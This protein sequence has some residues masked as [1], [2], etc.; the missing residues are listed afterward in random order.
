MPGYLEP[1]ELVHPTTPELEAGLDA[2][3]HSPADRGRV[4]QI[5]RRPAV[6]ER[7]ALTEAQLD[8][9]EGLV[10]DSWSRR[11]PDP[12]TQVTL[13]NA[14]VAALVSGSDDRWQL[15]GDQLYVDLDLSRTNLPPGT[16]LT[17][18]DHGAVIEITAEPHTGCRKFAGRFGMDAARFVNSREGR[19]LQLRGIN[20]KV[21][22]PGAVRVGD[23][24]RK[25][26]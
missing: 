23:P 17:I 15:A 16:R 25:L 2:I 26:E 14:R 3:R 21:V 18:G 12:E 7:E 4:E 6:D 5:V 9:V 10:G 1:V 19:E 22:L 24:V 13:M 20:A 8:T 11:R